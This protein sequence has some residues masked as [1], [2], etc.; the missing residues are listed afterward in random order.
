MQP[1][2]QQLCRKC[3]KEATHCACKSTLNTGNDHPDASTSQP[4][5]SQ[6]PSLEPGDDSLAY[7]PSTNAAVS[8]GEEH[9]RD[10]GSRSPSQQHVPGPMS[11]RQRDTSRLKSPEDV[12]GWPS[13]SGSEGGKSKSNTPSE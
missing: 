10:G 1:Q 2:P 11:T 9:T 12:L 3:N 7:S 4:R 6:L 8:S 13:G 5:L